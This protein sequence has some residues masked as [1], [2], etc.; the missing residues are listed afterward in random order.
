MNN[1]KN[2]IGGFNPCEIFTTDTKNSIMYEIKT[3]LEKL[4]NT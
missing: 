2:L 4:E 1:L 3:R